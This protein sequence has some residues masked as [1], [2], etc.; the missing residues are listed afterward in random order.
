MSQLCI[1]MEQESKPDL[2]ILKA[3]GVSYTVSIVSPYLHL[4]ELEEYTKRAVQAGAKVFITTSPALAG[5]VAGASS[6]ALPVVCAG[7]GVDQTPV[8]AA[9]NLE[10]AALAAGQILAAG[11]RAAGLSLSSYLAKRESEP[12][13]D[14]S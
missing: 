12:R 8:L 11:D 14:I 3:L 7:G 6:L 2:E 10:Q 1:F 5:A 13:F 9:A 4:S